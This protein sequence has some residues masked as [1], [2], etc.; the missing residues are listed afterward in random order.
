[1]RT[2]NIFVIGLAVITAMITACEKLPLQKSRK[3]ETSFFQNDLNKSVIEFMQSRQDLFAGTLDALAYVDEDPAYADVRQAY[4]SQGN[5]FLLM[6]DND[7]GPASYFAV[8]LIDDD[9]NPATPRVIAST[10]R[11]YPREQIANLLRY[12][13][14]KGRRDFA[15]L[16]STA[17]WFDTFAISPTNDSAKVRMFMTNDRDGLLRLNDYTGS[18]LSGIPRTPNLFATNG[19]VHVL[20]IYLIQ[21]TRQAIINNP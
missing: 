16:S 8:N 10:M 11:Q 14:V 18:I 6:A 2:K 5:T 1:M 20:N 12:H 3:Y 21:P 13:V 4:E 17:R 9:N 19:V 7:F 15:N